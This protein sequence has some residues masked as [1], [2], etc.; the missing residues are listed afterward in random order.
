MTSLAGCE[1]SSVSRK[2]IDDKVLAIPEN[3]LVAR[4]MPLLFGEGWEAGYA[5]AVDASALLL[6]S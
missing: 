5:T 3:N 2:D 1:I 4:S 6:A